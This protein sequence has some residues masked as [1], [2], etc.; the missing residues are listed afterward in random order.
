VIIAMGA[1]DNV[2]DG[3][4]AKVCR[5]L[6]DISYPLY[7]TH[8]ALI[9]TYTAWVVDRK[10]ALSKSVPMGVALFVTALAIAYAC[11]KLF[12]EPV[13]RWLSAR[14]LGRQRSDS[15]VHTNA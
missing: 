4:E 13:R 7:I 10:P 9:Y 11:L 2:R 5:F 8:Y 6:G 1:G 14:Y 3:V 12:D 15:T